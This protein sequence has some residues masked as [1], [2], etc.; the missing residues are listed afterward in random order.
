VSLG[1]LCS[2]PIIR[3]RAWSVLLG[4][5]A[6]L[7]TVIVPSGPPTRQLLVL[8]NKTGSFALGVPIALIALET[9]VLGALAIA[10]SVR[11]SLRRS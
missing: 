1:A 5:T 6:G 4:V 7:A 3:R 8:F 2:R 9:L 10:L 11:L